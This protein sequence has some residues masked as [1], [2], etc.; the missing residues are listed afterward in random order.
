MQC[1]QHVYSQFTNP[2]Y[3]RYNPPETNSVIKG[4]TTRT[5]YSTYGILQHV[6]QTNICTKHVKFKATTRLEMCGHWEVLGNLQSPSV[7][8][9]G[10]AL[11][12]EPIRPK[13]PEN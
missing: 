11:Q 5:E 9:L 4:Q 2:I 7:A 12:I 13:A 1:K 6:L 3:S 8:L 10:V